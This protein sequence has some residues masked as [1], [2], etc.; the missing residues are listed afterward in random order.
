MSTF[1]GV[2][3]SLSQ[4]LSQNRDFLKT[5]ILK[6]GQTSVYTV[7]K[8]VKDTKKQPVFG[9][10]FRFLVGVTGFEPMT[11]WSR[12]KRA[13]NCATPR[14]RSPAVSETI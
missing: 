13:T 2:I 3:Q 4:I 1:W 10:F 7:I 14:R 12:T 6:S 11:S 8:V 5:K 9:L